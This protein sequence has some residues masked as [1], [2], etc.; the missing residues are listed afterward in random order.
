YSPSTAGCSWGSGPE[1][2]H[3]ALCQEAEPVHALGVRALTRYSNAGGTKPKAGCNRR[4]L[5]FMLVAVIAAAISSPKLFPREPRDRS[6]HW[7]FPRFGGG[8]FARYRVS[9]LYN[10]GG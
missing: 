2:R 5:R 8:F 7:A 9:L 4:R 6:S 1:A 10:S 3:G